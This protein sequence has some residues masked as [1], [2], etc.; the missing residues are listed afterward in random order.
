LWNIRAAE[1][2]ACYCLGTAAALIFPWS[3]HAQER[4]C[5]CIVL[6]L[7]CGLRSLEHRV[8]RRRCA[9]GR[10]RPQDAGLHDRSIA[11]RSGALTKSCSGAR[12]ADE[13]RLTTSGVVETFDEESTM[14]K[15]VRC[16]DKSSSF[17]RPGCW[18]PRPPRCCLQRCRH[19]SRM[20]V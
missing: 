14:T 20:I 10:L 13:F 2:C 1:N 17:R 18:Q 19:V 5:T 8:Q 16:E 9:H 7:F 15:P 4:P 3:P 12:R 6:Q 11:V